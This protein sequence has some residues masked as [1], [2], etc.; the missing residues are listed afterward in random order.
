MKKETSFKT[1]LKNA[2]VA[3]KR[4]AARKKQPY[5]ISENGKVL[6][7]YPDKRQKVVYPPVRKKKSDEQLKHLDK[8]AAEFEAN[9]NI[10]SS[11]ETVKRKIIAST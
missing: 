11:W 3:A 8:I 7:V 10:G 9:P 1:L 5:A 2:A 6:L 4:A